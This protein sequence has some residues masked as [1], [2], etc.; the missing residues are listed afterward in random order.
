MVLTIPGILG[1]KVGVKLN[2]AQE[3]YL[4]L[5]SEDTFERDNQMWG[6]SERKY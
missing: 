1:S 3:S 2:V 4:V 5:N 6:K